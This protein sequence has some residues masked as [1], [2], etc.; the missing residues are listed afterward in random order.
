MNRLLLLI[1]WILS[2]ILMWSQKPVQLGLINAD[3][4]GAVLIKDSI[5]PVFSP[6]GFGNKLEISGFKLGDPMFIEQE[7]NSVW[8]KFTVPFDATLTFDIVPIHA[9][10]DFDF[11]L[12]FYDGPAFCQTIIENRATPVRSNI[13]RKNIDVKGYTGLSLSSVEE[14]VPS[15]PGSSYSRALPVKRGQ[16]YYLLV[17]NPFRENRGHSIYLTYHKKEGNS[18]PRKREEAANEEYN[19][20]TSKLRIKIFDV[21]TKDP[22]GSVITI[23]GM[24]NNE[25]LEYQNVSEK[26]IDIISYRSYSISS[27]AKG[28]MLNTKTVIP[29]KQDEYLVEI[30]L[31]KIAPGAKITLEAIKFEED[32][33]IFLEKSLP[34]LKQL[35]TF[36]SENPNVQVEIAGHVNGLGKK[37][38]KEFKDLSTMR[39][40]A[41]SDYVSMQGIPAS[42]MEVKGYGNAEMLFPEPLNSGQ[43]EANRR[44][45]I[46]ILKD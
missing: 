33:A 25:I 5:G 38:K 1:C 10:D 31:K 41:V 12:F 7:H 34:A 13:S 36:L 26:I 22:V 17:D 3:C 16:Q 42:R 19:P 35:I 11:M 20:L 2:P 9:D 43:M 24:P 27:V 8:Y 44:V 4:I 15:G 30:G 39:A 21:D 29:S 37:N 14:Y 32:K 23:E 45:E 46:K 28:Y 18:D 40:Q 6:Q